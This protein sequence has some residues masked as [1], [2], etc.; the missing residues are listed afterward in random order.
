MLC[1]FGYFPSLSCIKFPLCLIHSI[2]KAIYHQLLGL[3]LTEAESLLAVS[4][5]YIVNNVILVFPCQTTIWLL[6]L[7]LGL[8]HLTCH[9]HIWS[10]AENVSKMWKEFWHATQLNFYIENSSEGHS[11]S[12]IHINTRVPFIGLYIYVKGSVKTIP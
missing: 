4:D 6:S 5:P 9:C 3:T 7:A 11:K 10:A 12:T 8:K 2:I 1:E